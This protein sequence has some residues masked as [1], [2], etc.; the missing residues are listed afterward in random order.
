MVEDMKTS[1]N[2]NNVQPMLQELETYLQELTAYNVEQKLKWVP[3]EGLEL[4]QDYNVVM[5]C[6]ERWKNAS[7]IYMANKDAWSI[8]N[9][10]IADIGDKLES[11]E[12]KY[13]LIVMPKSYSYDINDLNMFNKQE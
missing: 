3:T 8:S 1:G 10:M 9:K 4:L 7:D 2:F 13:N 11:I 6:R 5:Q 12:L